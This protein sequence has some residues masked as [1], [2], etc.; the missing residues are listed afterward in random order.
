MLSAQTG[1][2]PGPLGHVYFVP[3]KIK[4][5]WECQWLLGYKGIIDLARRSGQL[6]SIEA[7]EVCERDDF[8]YAY[9]LDERLHHRPSDD[10]DRGPL[11]HVYGI[12]KFVA[13]GHYFVVMGRADIELARARS[14]AFKAG[15]GPWVTDFA[16]MARKTVIRRMAPYLPLSAE[17]AN[18]IAHD[19]TVNKSTTVD[20]KA[21][22]PEASWVDVPSYEAPPEPAAP[23]TQQSGEQTAERASSQPEPMPSDDHEPGT[24]GFFPEDDAAPD[25]GEAMTDGQSRALHALLRA[26]HGASGDARFPVLSAMLGREVTTTKNVTK[27]E[28]STLIDSL[29]ELPDA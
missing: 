16:A 18:M 7:R 13:G 14:D 19:E 17:V 8:D 4:G 12:A 23:Q 2:E 28:A 21:E 25:P 5:Q 9:G 29:N 26:K 20:P 10:G 24:G 11:T 1:L 3:R 15:F 6:Q 22:P 27:R